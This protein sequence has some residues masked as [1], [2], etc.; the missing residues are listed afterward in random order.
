MNSALR[1]LQ[2]VDRARYVDAYRRPARS[3]YAISFYP[4][5]LGSAGGHVV[6]TAVA[7]A[8]WN[9]SV[10]LE[11]RTH[12]SRDAHSDATGLTQRAWTVQT[13]WLH[14]NQ[15]RSLMSGVARFHRAGALRRRAVG[16]PDEQGLDGSPESMHEYEHDLPGTVS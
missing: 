10:A 2:R 16:Y 12:C 8:S 11:R 13:Q 7:G 6:S 4:Y 1:W 3:H 15:A 14:W 9:A 5:F